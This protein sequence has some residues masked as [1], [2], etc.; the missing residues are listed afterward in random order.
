MTYKNYPF[1]YAKIR[2][3]QKSFSFHGVLTVYQNAL[4]LEV[5]EVLEKDIKGL[6]TRKRI[7]EKFGA[8]NFA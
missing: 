1:I 2:F 8:E 6:K 5:L 4:A 7:K 3:L